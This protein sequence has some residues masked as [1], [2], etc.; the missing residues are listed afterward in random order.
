MKDKKAS[1]CENANVDWLCRVLGWQMRV[2]KPLES[3]TRSLHILSQPSRNPRVL[4]ME[5]CRLY[6]RTERHPIWN[7]SI[8]RRCSND[9]YFCSCHLKYLRKHMY[10]ADWFIISHLPTLYINTYIYY[11]FPFDK[12]T[13]RLCSNFQSFGKFF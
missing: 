12:S 5:S 2:V 6:E 10:D 4:P 7:I 1:Y 11:S 13:L 8:S 9:V 3:L